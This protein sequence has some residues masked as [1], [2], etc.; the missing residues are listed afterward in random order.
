VDANVDLVSYK[1]KEVTKLG[2][3]PRSFVVAVIS[4]F[5]SFLPGV[6]EINKLWSIAHPRQLAHVQAICGDKIDNSTIFRFCIKYFDFP[7]FPF[8]F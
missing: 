6:D 7:Y 8:P 1:T 4:R 5:Y 2:L 3:L